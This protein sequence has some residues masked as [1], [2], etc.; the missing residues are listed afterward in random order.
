L[1][2]HRHPK[3]EW[4]LLLFFGSFTLS[5]ETKAP[6][7]V[8]AFSQKYAQFKTLS[9]SFN[10]A[11]TSEN[12]GNEILQSGKLFIEKP[13]KM[14]WQ[15]ETPERKDIIS[16]GKNL[17]VYREAQKQAFLQPGFE[18]MKGEVGLSFLWGESKLDV[19]FDVSISPKTMDGMTELTLTPKLSSTSIDFITLRVDDKTL[20][21]TEATLYD[22]QRNKN[23]F[24]FE[25]IEFDPKLD[26]S[27]A[28]PSTAEI[29]GA[30]T[31][32]PSPKKA[33]KAGKKK[34]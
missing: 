21:L 31:D 20:F 34:K 33:K 23:H 11:F 27:F 6:K 4:I 12:F 29:L 22:K 2:K 7:I 14:R 5:A 15:Y 1:Q 17:W 16:D 18:N 25:Q 8:E 28:P 30:K 32:T 26:V 24:R 9:C 3:V 13:G 10:Q 19:D